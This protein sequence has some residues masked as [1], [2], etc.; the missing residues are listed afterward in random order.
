[1]H[2]S[3]NKDSVQCYDGDEHHEDI[4]Q[5]EQDEQD[6]EEV[7]VDQEERVEQGER[8]EQDQQDVSV[9]HT[10]SPFK[11]KC[12]SDPAASPIPSP[13][14][15]KTAQI[16]CSKHW[17]IDGDVIVQLVNFTFKLQKSWLAKL[18]TWFCETFEE[19][20]ILNN[21]EEH[22]APIVVDVGGFSVHD[23]EVL[24]DALDGVV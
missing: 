13:K 10:R 7:H 18:S 1:V 14:R 15:T 21:S 12:A 16:Q 3:E 23:F 4:E 2:L 8:V 11:R 22:D 9:V 6:E 24:L 20:G 17:E 5:D 19:M